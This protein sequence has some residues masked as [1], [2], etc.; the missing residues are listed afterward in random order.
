MMRQKTN[1]INT[2]HVP[3]RQNTEEKDQYAFVVV[4]LYP[5]CIIQPKPQS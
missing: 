3:V 1:E 2:Q 4:I 5:Y